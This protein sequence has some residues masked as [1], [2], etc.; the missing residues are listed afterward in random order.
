F[1]N[2]EGDLTGTVGELRFKNISSGGPVWELKGDTDGNGVS[3]FE[4]ILIIS[5]ADPITASDFIL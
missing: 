2:G 1:L 5:P 3:D 4:L